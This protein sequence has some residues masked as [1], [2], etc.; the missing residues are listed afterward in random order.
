MSRIT[1]PVDVRRQE[2]IDTARELFVKNGYDVTQMADISRKMNV[3]SGLVYYYFKSKTDILYK[4]IDEI[5]DEQLNSL[6][7]ILNKNDNKAKDKL[8]IMFANRPNL[9]K[10]KKFIESIEREQAI[11][12]YCNNRLNSTLLPILISLIEQGN[13]DGSWDCKYPKEIAIFILKGF[14]GFAEIKGNINDDVKNMLEK[15]IFSILN[16]H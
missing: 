15:V 10:Y 3:A 6:N 8:T 12:E 9:N 2:I 13:S 16:L 14:S 1:K 4:V 11:I 7:N 5:G